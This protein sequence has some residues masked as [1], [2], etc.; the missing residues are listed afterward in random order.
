M[1]ESVEWLRALVL[2]YPAFQYAIIFLGTAFG[3]EAGVIA[4]SFLAAQHVFSF[5]PFLI[6]SVLGTLFGDTLWFYM[7]RTRMAGKIIGHRYAA[8]TVSVIVEAINRLSR[9]NHLLAFVLAKFLIG[10]RAVLILY[11]SKTGISLKDF[12]QHNLP[13]IFIWFS[14]VGAIGYLAGLGF[15]FIAGVLENIYAG[16]GFALLIFIM[17]IIAQV[18]LKRT[19]VKEEKKIMEEENMI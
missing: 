5:L 8:N 1:V 12:M 19:F 18:W 2:H 9:G 4:L 15:T 13:A 11:V 6:L 16:A 17:V 7:G 14:V 10:T 3:G